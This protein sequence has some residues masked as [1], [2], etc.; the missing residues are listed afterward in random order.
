[1]LIVHFHL[2]K[3]RPVPDQILILPSQVSGLMTAQRNIQSAILLKKA[4]DS[5]TLPAS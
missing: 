3:L 1:M 5:S 4:T 2:M